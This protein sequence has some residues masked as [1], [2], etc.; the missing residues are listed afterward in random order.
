MTLMHFTMLVIVYNLHV[1]T[2]DMYPSGERR[3]DLPHR[4]SPGNI[5]VCAAYTHTHMNV[6]L[7]FIHYHCRY[8]SPE[9]GEVVWPA[10]TSPPSCMYPLYR[11]TRYILTAA[12]LLYV[13]QGGTN[14]LSLL[15]LLW[16]P[17]DVV[18]VPRQTSCL[19][20]RWPEVPPPERPLDIH[21]LVID[22]IVA[23]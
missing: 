6:S 22:H 2:A 9:I 14:I 3:G 4:P 23:R 11:R 10:P 20:S 5:H 16:I 1:Y 21:T 18:Q 13:R 19:F 15:L 8:I 12:H 7:L 17:I